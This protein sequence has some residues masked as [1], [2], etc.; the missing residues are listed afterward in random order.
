V[1]PMFLFLVGSSGEGLLPASA[2]ASGGPWY[3]LVYGL[4]VLVVSL[5]AWSC[6]STWRDLRPRPSPA[7]TLLAVVLGLLVT[8]LW[9]V[10]AGRY[11]ALPFTGHR[12]AYNPTLLPEPAR[13]AFILVRLYGLVVLVPLIEELFWRSF[14]VRWIVRPDFWT[15]PIGR[16]TR[17]AAIVVSVLFA[18][19]HPE[20]LPALITGFLWIW[21][22]HRTRSVFACVVSHATAN[23]A[24]A[25]YVLVTGAWIFW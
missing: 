3:P 8:A 2:G 5:V 14:L 9:I 1:A 10:F 12:T 16:V 21:L 25:L 20:W 13:A 22:L 18:V 24:L 6:R 17:R 7:Q 23:L 4:K 19:V 11:P 15:I